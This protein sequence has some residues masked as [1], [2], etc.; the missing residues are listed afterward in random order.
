MSL[1]V[2]V[3]SLLEETGVQETLVLSFIFTITKNYSSRMKIDIR[4]WCRV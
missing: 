3:F 4:A 2:F 1:L